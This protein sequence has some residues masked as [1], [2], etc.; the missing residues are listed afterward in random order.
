MDE[1][2]AKIVSEFAPGELIT[3][4]YM[5]ELFQISYPQIIGYKS[6]DTFLVDYQNIQF[7]Y[8]SAIDKL[9]DE[10]LTNEMYYLRNIRGDGY[11][12]MPPKD[13]V[14][15]AFDKAID[16]I[17]KDIRSAKDIM[18]NVR[19]DMIPVELQSKNHDLIARLSGLQQLFSTKIK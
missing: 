3:H 7:R 17:K 4:D 8:M 12:L 15:Y 19:T 11:V 10:L 9:R 18:L 13:Q 6:T 16:D 1:L 14:Q 2:A 5:M